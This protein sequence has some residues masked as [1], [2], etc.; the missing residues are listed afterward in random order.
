ME[1]EWLAKLSGPVLDAKPL[2]PA[3]LPRVVGDQCAGVADIVVPQHKEKSFVFDDRSAV[4][5][6]VLVGVSPILR[7]RAPLAG[8]SVDIAVIQPC[9][10]VERRVPDVPY[11]ASIIPVGSRTC[12]DLNL[13][14]AA[15]HFRVDR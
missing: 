12:L 10:R 8:E 13:P 2:Y 15:S 14:V 7:R 1:R 6:R 11:R 4:A 5:Q 3:E 9:V